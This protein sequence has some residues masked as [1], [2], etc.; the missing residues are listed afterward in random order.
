[1]DLLNCK[2][3]AKSFTIH[4]ELITPLTDISFTIHE[5]EKIVITGKSGAGKSVLLSLLCGLDRPSSGE[6][7]YRD[8]PFSQMSLS[9]LDQL[10]YSDIG[11]IF[12]NHNLVSSW[13]VLENV[14]AALVQTVL[15]KKIRHEQ[16]KA[17]LSNLGM[18]QRLHH[19]PHHLSMGEQQ[20]VAIARTIIRCPRLILADEPTGDVDPETAREIIR[21]LYQAVDKE[22]CT[23]LI[24]THGNFP[25]D[26]ADRVFVLEKGKLNSN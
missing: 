12:Q 11:I 20:R 16:A 17:L 6:I 13:T 3:V 18:E 4:N 7:Y 23:L 26:D 14:E 10:R 21:L 22:N 15:S 8:A 25:L 1:M 9:Q 5:R 19:L 2:N 24:A